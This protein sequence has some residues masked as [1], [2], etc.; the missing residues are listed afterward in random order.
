[1]LDKQLCKLFGV[2]PY[3]EWIQNQLDDL[4]DQLYSG[5]LSSESM[6]K[7]R[8]KYEA[9]IEAR[10]TYCKMEVTHTMG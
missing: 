4:E 5:K 3:L 7:V 9:L 1:M 10:D 2:K 8:A 6:L